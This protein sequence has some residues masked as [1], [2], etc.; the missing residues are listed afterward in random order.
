MKVYKLLASDS[1]VPLAEI[2]IDDRG[3]KMEVFSDN[4][5]GKITN[6]AGDDF[7]KLLGIVNHSS[8]LSLEETK[9]ATVGLLRYLTSNGDVIEMTTDGHTCMI[10]GS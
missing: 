1:Q 3:N 7:Q 10:N 8:T 5:N 4:T 2:R 6:M 9:D